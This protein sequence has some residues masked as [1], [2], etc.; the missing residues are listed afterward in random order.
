MMQNVPALERLTTGRR[1]ALRSTDFEQVALPYLDA[2]ARFAWSLTRNREDADDL[3]Q[4]TFLRAYRGWHTFDPGNDPRPWIF[5]ICRNTF[6]R[7][8]RTRGQLVESDDGDVDA[9]PAVME[10]IVAQEAGLGQMFEQL[11]LGSAIRQAVHHLPEPHHSVLVLV[12]LEER[13]YADA[14]DVLMIP[15]GTVRSR[16]FRARRMAQEALIAYAQD[17]GLDTRSVNKMMMERRHN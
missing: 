5:A 10:H 8:R 4:E 13:S 6:V 16:L 7:W 9:I 12:D 14:A 3:V 11:E 17:R 2:V 1:N 15:V